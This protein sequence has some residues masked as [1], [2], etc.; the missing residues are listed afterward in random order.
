MTSHVSII[1]LLL[2]LCGAYAQLG[3]RIGTAQRQ[4]IPGSVIEEAATAGS[5]SYFMISGVSKYIFLK[6]TGYGISLALPNDYIEPFAVSPSAQLNGWIEKEVRAPLSEGFDITDVVFADAP[7]SEE[8][9]GRFSASLAQALENLVA[10]LDPLGVRVSLS[11]RLSD[12]K[13]SYPPSAGSFLDALRAPLRASLSVA[14]SVLFIADPF[15]LAA[16]N[17]DP[18]TV[19][20]L[21]MSD[22]ASGYYDNEGKLYYADVLSASLDAAVY[23]LEELGFP[24]A[25][26][27]LVTGW[28]TD[29]ATYATRDLASTYVDGVNEWANSADGTPKRPASRVKTFLRSLLDEDLRPIDVEPW[30]RRW[31]LYDAYGRYKLNTTTLRFHRLSGGEFIER[32]ADY[33]VVRSDA[34]DQALVS[35]I[36]YACQRADC[37]S[38]QINSSC[39]EPFSLRMHATVVYNEYYQDAGQETSSC[40]FGATAVESKSIPY[41]TSVECEIRRG[42]VFESKAIRSTALSVVL[43]LFAAAVSSI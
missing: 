17:P 2:P 32:P 35:G 7:L 12:L 42:I 29:G 20:F 22:S 8:N 6:K 9:G 13:S 3:V 19:A 26:L 40:D 34:A 5:F 30:Q 36:A 14:P 33:C 16:S 27:Q 28:P 11:V 4:A 38:I 25:T 39:Y 24:N 15:D 18:A 31:G 37:T 10:Q 43:V 41:A 1:A 23:A 21:D